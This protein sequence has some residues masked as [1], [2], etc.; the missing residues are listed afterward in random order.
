MIIWVCSSWSKC[1][2]LYCKIRSLSMRSVS[3]CV[4][5]DKIRALY[6]AGNYCLSLEY[7]HFEVANHVRHS[8][9]EE[10]KVD[11]LRRF[12]EY[13]PS[14]SNT[15]RMPANAGRTTNAGQGQKHNTAAYR[16]RPHWEKRFNSEHRITSSTISLSDP[17]GTTENE[18]ELHHRTNLP[19][20]VSNAREIVAD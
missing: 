10:R 18:F 6:R 4:E 14:I 2:L 1:E 19:K 15:F 12:R 11:H 13:V 17:Q 3:C 8:W 5:N 16:G 20:S 7:R 9:S